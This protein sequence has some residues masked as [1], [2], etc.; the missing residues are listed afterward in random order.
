M[1]LVSFVGGEAG[2]RFLADTNLYAN[3]VCFQ[4]DL[5]LG[6]KGPSLAVLHSCS[7]FGAQTLRSACLQPTC[8]YLHIGDPAWVS[9]VLQYLPL[10]IGGNGYGWVWPE[11]CLFVV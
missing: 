6:Q 8:L 10:L 9:L 7:R 5:K 1:P 11:Y 2:Q 4:G 3:Q